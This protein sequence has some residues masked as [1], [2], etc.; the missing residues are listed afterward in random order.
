MKNQTR[1]QFIKSTAAGTA[2]VMLEQLACQESGNTQK[3][4]IIYIL[5]DD[6][7]YKELGCY[8]Q[9]KIRTPNIDDLAAQGMR[10]TQHYS[11][12]PVC[13]PSRCTLM[14]GKHTGH[15][16]VRDNDEMR[17][18]GDVWNDPRI[19]GQRPLPPGTV[20]MGTLLQ[21]AGYKTACIGKWGLGGPDDSGHPNEQGFDLFYGYLCQRQAHN[22]YPTH[23]WRN[24]EKDIFEGN[25]YFKPHQKLP[26]NKDPNDP[27]SYTPYSG[28]H[29]APDRMIEEA[30]GFIERNS[31]N[32]F[33][34][35]FATPV[36]HLALQVPEDSLDEYKNAFPETPYIGD[37]GY[38]PH[39]T[40]RAAYAAMITRL[41][42]DVGRILSLLKKLG[43]DENTVILLSSDNGATYTGG[44]DYTYFDSVGPL[45]GLKGSL[46][47]GGI[48][49]PMVARWTGKI[50]SGTE[51][52]HI[53]AFWDIMPTLCELSGMD[54]PEDTD[55]ISLLPRLLNRGKQQEHP[56]LYWEF[57]GYGG[58]QAIRM[59]DWKG[60]RRNMHKG[61]RRIELYNL[62]E[63]IGE[64]NDLANNY[65]DRV[66]QMGNIMQET[67]TPSEFEKWNFF[68]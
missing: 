29:Y 24:K 25:A 19:E 60:I 28:K 68:D 12:S 44:V 40:P 58:Q 20:T 42:R 57:A 33:F 50:K 49:V 6:L 10:F 23:L 39:Q 54:C 18:K 22:Y 5:A 45:N 67:R 51:S 31:G 47:E 15:S 1:R 27:K 36:P 9:E 59:G 7:G 52:D 26:D 3:P 2:S 56:Y 4:N 11:G 30:L 63:D 13:A 35:Y 37:R 32:P 21:K 16:Y 48:R 66:K 55:G 38:T 41:D 8:G 61:N 46:Y 17:E 14:T 53:S 62:K 64:K 43:L 34:L 65:P